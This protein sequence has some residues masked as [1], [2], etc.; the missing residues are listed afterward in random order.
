MKNDIIETRK[1]IPFDR[2]GEFLATEHP[3][4]DEERLLDA[5]DN[6]E[7][8]YDDQYVAVYADKCLI[9]YLEVK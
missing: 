2:L 8:D 5:I 4:F 6:F 1:F 3:S 9:G 7:S